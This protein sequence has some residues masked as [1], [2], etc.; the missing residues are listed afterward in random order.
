MTHRI[1]RFK[2]VK[3]RDGRSKSTLYAAMA[4][5]TFP[6]P[7]KLG[8]RSVGWLESELNAMIAARAKGFS[9]A[10]IRKFV[11]CLVSARKDVA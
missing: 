2:E 10:E 11:E 7:I 3:H 5:G 6:S 9:E 1:I 8:A 4:D